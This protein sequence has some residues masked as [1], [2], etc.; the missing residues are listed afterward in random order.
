M[1]VCVPY[2]SDPCVCV[3]LKRGNDFLVFFSLTDFKFNSNSKQQ[4][5]H[6]EKIWKSVLA[7]GLLLF[8]FWCCG[9]K[10]IFFSLSLSLT[11]YILHEF[12]VV[13][14]WFFFWFFGADC[15]WQANQ[16]WMKCRQPEKMYH[17][18]SQ[19]AVN[20]WFFFL[21]SIFFSEADVKIN[22]VKMVDDDLNRVWVI[23]SGSIFWWFFLFV[24]CVVC[25]IENQMMWNHFFFFR[26]SENVWK[27]FQVYESNE[28]KKFPGNYFQL[29]QC[30]RIFIFFLSFFVVLIN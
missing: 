20:F 4:Q 8:V 29:F 17:H 18:A 28:S 19:P 6:F 15:H 5:Q 3:W 12:F 21:A 27:F 16:V 23:F 10:S 24:F 13:S 9:F 26:L 11:T 30:C 7:A 1:F 25:C 22:L 2:A 14:F